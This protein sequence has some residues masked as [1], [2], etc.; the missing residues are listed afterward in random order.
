MP[1]PTPARPL[2]VSE[3]QGPVAGE[4]LRYD[5]TIDFRLAIFGGEAKVRAE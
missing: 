4:D 1:S 5:L 2:L 3:P